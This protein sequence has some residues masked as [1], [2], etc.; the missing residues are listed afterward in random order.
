MNDTVVR[1]VV[2]AIAVIWTTNGDGWI[3]V[4]HEGSLRLLAIHIVGVFNVDPETRFE[5]KTAKHIRQLLNR[6]V[7][8]SGQWRGRMLIA[9]SVREL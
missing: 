5:L 9:R 6:Q 7:E 3:T 8:V 4:R 2:T 1:G